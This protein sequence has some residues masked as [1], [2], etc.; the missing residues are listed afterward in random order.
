MSKLATRKR[1]KKNQTRFQK[2]W[3]RVERLK[4]EITRRDQALDALAERV[5]SDIL[6]R[7]QQ[8]ARSNMLILLRLLDL[9]QRKSWTNWQRYEIEHWIRENMGIAAMGGHISDE[10]RDQIAR[11]DAFRMGVELDENDG[12][13]PGEQLDEIMDEQQRL[14]EQAAEAQLEDLQEQLQQA[15]EQLIEK[16]LNKELGKRPEDLG[17]SG[18]TDDMWADDRE[19][20]LRQAQQ[21]YDTRRAKRREEL[22]QELEEELDDIKA[23]FDDID[24]DFDPEEL[25]QPFENTDAAFKL[26]NA[27]A[28]RMF[29]S[30]AAVLHPDREPDPERRLEKQKLMAQLLAARK[31]GD[32]M[33]LLSLYQEHVENGQA[34]SKADEKQLISALEK[35]VKKLEEDLEYYSPSSPL[36]DTA[37]ELY[38]PHKKTVEKNIAAY[39]QLI[40]RAERVNTQLAE[41]L[42]SMAALKPHLEDRYDKRR[43]MRHREIMSQIY[44]R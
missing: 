37:L 14:S 25:N 16:T 44:D 15:R 7:E 32:I 36:H 10:V 40:D 29:R 42:S 21:D 28:Q 20:I 9:G 22:T 38:S 33:T 13:S 12:R 27:A 31:S 8:M 5:R 41:S 26:D 43:E 1:N 11:Y 35:Q 2:M 4:S 17:A 19:E 3:Q 39:L 34:L 6:P 18:P 30:A 24:F 23:D